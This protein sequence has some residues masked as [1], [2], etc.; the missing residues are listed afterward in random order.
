MNLERKLSQRP[1]VEELADRH[2]LRLQEESS[3]DEKR[4][5]LL[6]KVRRISLSL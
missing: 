5:M 1:T 6:R 3:M 4:K 2:I